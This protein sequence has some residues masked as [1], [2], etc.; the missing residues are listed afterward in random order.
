MYIQQI[1]YF[2]TYQLFS[3][4]H[5]ILAF[6]STANK[7]TQ[8]RKKT[9]I[10]DGLDAKKNGAFMMRRENMHLLCLRII[11]LSLTISLQFLIKYILF[12]F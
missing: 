10:Y 5:D 4:F 2:G 11:I 9:L 7:I 6:S 3:Q 8:I 1:Q 12:V